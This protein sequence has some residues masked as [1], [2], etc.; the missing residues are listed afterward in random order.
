MLIAA[1][2]VADVCLK[3]DSVIALNAIAFMTDLTI[4]SC[5]FLGSNCI[6]ATQE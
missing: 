5:S 6:V 2:L 4:N 1:F 3:N